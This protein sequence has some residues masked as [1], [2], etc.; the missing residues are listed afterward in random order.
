MMGCVYQLRNL[1]FRRQSAESEF[2]LKIDKLDIKRG[3]LVAFVGPSGCG[4]STL[5][6]II[7]F[8][9]GHHRADLFRFSP[10]ACSDVADIS[11]KLSQKSDFLARLRRDFIGYVPQIGGLIPSL[12]ALQNIELP[13]R[14]TGRYDR[15]HI[16]DLV[17]V[18]KIGGCC[19]KKPGQLSVGER[20]RVAIAR[21]IAH[22]PS[23]IIADEPTAALDPHNAASV[24]RLFVDL[25]RSQGKTL[26]L[27]SHDRDAIR[28]LAITEIE[29]V[30]QANA[31]QVVSSIRYA[32]EE[33]S[34][35]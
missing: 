29:L 32:H 24:M 9:L 5:V 2:V 17:S 20:Q 1:I 33:E 26:I 14:L 35:A 16:R 34:Y 22:G 12:T 4:K 13:C 27:V 25:V 6:D 19:G 11:T 31:G 28:E 23:V 15:N 3:E 18:L 30:P 10:D 7:A 21:A 8:L